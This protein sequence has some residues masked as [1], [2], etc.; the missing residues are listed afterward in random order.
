MEPSGAETW[1]QTSQ[2]VEEALTQG[3]EASSFFPITPSRLPPGKAHAATV[4]PEDQGMSWGVATEAEPE[5]W[6]NDPCCFGPQ[7]VSVCAGRPHRSLWGCG[8]YCSWALLWVCLGQ[9]DLRALRPGASEEQVD[10][11]A[12]EVGQVGFRFCPN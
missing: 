4:L 2:Q 1:P 10:I 3:Q 7:L 8:H 9:A 6:Q 12:G 11:R 5:A